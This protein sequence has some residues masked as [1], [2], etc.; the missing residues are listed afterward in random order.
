MELFNNPVVA[1]RLLSLGSCL[2][3]MSRLFRPRRLHIRLLNPQW[4]WLAEEWIK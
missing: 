3:E 2:V 4:R 1:A